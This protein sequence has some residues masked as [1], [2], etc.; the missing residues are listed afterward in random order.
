V[1]DAH[2]ARRRRSQVE[3][4][5]PRAAGMQWDDKLSVFLILGLGRMFFALCICFCFVFVFVLD[6]FFSL[7]FVFVGRSDW[8][9]IGAQRA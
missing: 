6:V 8:P 5:H 7:L 4:P 3:V 2:P 1:Q 9:G